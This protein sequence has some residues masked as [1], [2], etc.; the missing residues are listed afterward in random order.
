M[1]GRL[2]G[3]RQKREDEGAQAG[4]AAKGGDGKKPRGEEK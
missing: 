1:N 4:K 3:T 2:V